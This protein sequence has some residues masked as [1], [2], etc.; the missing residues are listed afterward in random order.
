MKRTVETSLRTY[1]L[2]QEKQLQFVSAHMMSSTRLFCRL[3]NTETK[4][5]CDQFL[6]PTGDELAFQ[7]CEILSKTVLQ[8]QVSYIPSKDSL[9]D[10]VTMAF[11]L[12]KQQEESTHKKAAVRCTCG[13]AYFRED[14]PFCGK[15]GTKRILKLNKFTG[16]S[17]RELLKLALDAFES[18][19]G[20]LVS[21]MPAFNER[22]VKI[23]RQG[24]CLRFSDDG[25]LELWNFAEKYESP[26]TVLAKWLE[27]AEETPDNIVCE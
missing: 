23:N 17:V 2:Q 26:T 27:R 16:L 12:D 21:E 6:A 7:R 19:T 25:I 1:L 14:D 22:F 24:P 15:C 3:V 18:R 5:T 4:M 13:A 8:V 20:L 10:A 9:P 11:P